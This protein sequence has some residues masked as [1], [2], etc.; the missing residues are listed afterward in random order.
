MALF[1][2]ISQEDWDVLGLVEAALATHVQLSRDIGASMSC[3][4]LSHREIWFAQTSLP[5][6]FRKGM[7]YMPVTPGQVFHLDSQVTL[8]KAEQALCRR[9]SV[10][11]TFGCS[12]ITRVIS[13]LSASPL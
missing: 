11:R 9:E 12:R 1:K 7:T 8:D 4:I 3:A 6:N 13:R 10:Q 2:I 5:D